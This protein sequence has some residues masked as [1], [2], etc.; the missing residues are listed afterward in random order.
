MMEKQA[1]IESLTPFLRQDKKLE[2][3]R[4]QS[5]ATPS[6]YTTEMLELTRAMEV[7]STL[8]SLDLRGNVVHPGIAARLRRTME[9]KRA[10]LASDGYVT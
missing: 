2:S 7:N 6:Y 5:I 1:G 3:L 10:S 8:A 4:A 9:E